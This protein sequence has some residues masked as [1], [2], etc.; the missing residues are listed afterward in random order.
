MEKAEVW[1]KEALRANPEEEQP[2]FES[3]RLDVIPASMSWS[4]WPR[5][6]TSST[7]TSFQMTSLPSLAQ[8]RANAFWPHPWSWVLHVF[9][10]QDFAFGPPVGPRWNDQL[11]FETGRKVAMKCE[12]PDRQ[13][14]FGNLLVSYCKTCEQNRGCNA[15]NKWRG[16]LSLDS[17]NFSD[18]NHLISGSHGIT[19]YIFDF[20][21]SNHADS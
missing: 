15:E 9:F 21:C 12:L 20:L 16:D 5:P 7:P 17:H 8:P 3:Y 10:S 4:G 13:Y 11:N 2:F 14:G 6:S 19:L 1:I 18:I